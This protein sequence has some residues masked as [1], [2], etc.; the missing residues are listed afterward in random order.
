VRRGPI[1]HQTAAHRQALE[2]DIAAARI[3]GDP[4][5]DLARERQRV[6]GENERRL[7]LSA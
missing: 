6:L 7:R 4:L 1:G 3:D 2:R 5:E